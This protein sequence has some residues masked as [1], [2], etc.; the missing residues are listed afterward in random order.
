M[1]KKDTKRLKKL[2]TVTTIT[3]I[4]LLVT[5]FAWFIGMQIVSVTSFDIEIAATDSLLLSL[6]GKKWNTTVSITKETVDEVS[7]PG[8]TNRWGG[9]GLIP[10][11][12]IGEV[13]VNSSRLVFF[14]KSSFTATSGGHRIMASRVHNTG[15]AEADGY[16]AFDLF[17]KNFSGPKYF[18]IDDVLNEEAIYLSIESEVNV[19]ETGIANTGIENSVRVA[20]AQIGRVSAAV[21]DQELITS[22]TCNANDVGVPSIKDGITGICRI[23]QIWEPNDIYHVENAIK[24]YD[25]TCRRRVG[26]QI[27]M[28]TAYS[29]DK[30]HQLEDETYYPTYA[31]RQELMSSD[32]VDIYD[33]QEYNSYAPSP[34]VMKYPYFTDT[35][36]DMPGVRRPTFMTLAPNSITKVRV[37]IYIEGQDID[38]YDYAAI[39]KRIS[40]HFGFTKDRLTEEDFDYDGPDIAPARDVT[41]PV[42]TLIGDPIVRI[43]TGS[44]YTDEG[45]T[46]DDNLEGDI[47]EHI[48]VQ[49][50]VNTNVEG[51]YVVRYNVRD[52][53]GN[54]AEEVIRT[55]IVED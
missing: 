11:S 13:D 36:R 9:R 53:A 48:V 15:E 45:A 27:H 54:W 7:Y 37:Y 52:W 50:H 26:T 32:N 8:H 16:V 46:A 30:C 25:A 49:N 44:T 41:P 2:I 31:I 43:A 24:F 39:G 40:V 20:F 35:N 18:E 42:I 29:S 5:T 47:T 4:L 55:V 1:T 3:A 33:G 12:T 28:P 23:G 17:I 38:N 21:T 19:A 22:I 6:D 51:T 14:E 10:M 34:K